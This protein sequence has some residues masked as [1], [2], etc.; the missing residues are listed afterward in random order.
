V[1]LMAAIVVNA[2]VVPIKL[3]VRIEVIRRD[4]RTIP[5]RTIPLMMRILIPTG[6]L[7]GAP[8]AGLI[9]IDQI[10]TGASDGASSPDGGDLAL[11][12]SPPPERAAQAGDSGGF[13]DRKIGSAL[14][15]F[16]LLWRN[17]H[18]PQE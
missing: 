8:A 18:A 1:V 6:L 12:Y 17:P 11:K 5:L 3:V 10:T 15:Y 7:I 16:D 14:G 9:G 13:G 4:A 2:L